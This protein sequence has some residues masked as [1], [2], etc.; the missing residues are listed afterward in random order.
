M[1]PNATLERMRELARE[2]HEAERWRETTLADELVDLIEGL[3]QWLSRGGFLPMAW[4]GAGNP[5]K[6]RTRW[7]ETLTDRQIAVRAAQPPPRDPFPR[8][9]R[10]IGE[11][12]KELEQIIADQPCSGQK[13]MEFVEELGEADGTARENAPEKQEE[14]R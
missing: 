9:R 6:R 5:T 8:S 2:Y 1:D 10:L 11:A 3:D 4:A 14:P 7:H 13:V 12:I